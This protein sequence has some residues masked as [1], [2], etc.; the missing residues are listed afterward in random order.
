MKICL[1]FCHLVPSN[2]VARAAIGIAN[3]ISEKMPG[4]DVTLIPLYKYDKMS[5]SSLLNPSVTVKKAIGFYFHGLDKIIRLLPHSFWGKIFINSEY[6]I[7]I[8]F[9][10]GL[11]TKIVGALAPSLKSRGVK[12]FGW[13]HGY[14]DGLSYLKYYLSIGHM[15]CVSKTNA[16]RLFDESG[17]KL[18]VDYCYNPINDKAIC[19]LGKDSISLK[20]NQFLQLVTVARL[21]PEK[22]FFRLLECITR[23]KQEGYLFNLWIIGNG[24]LLKELQRKVIQDNIE[25]YV[26]FL[27]EQMNPHKFTSKADLFVCPSFSEG[28]STACTEAVMLGVPVLSTDVSG[29][30]EIT[31]MAE[32]GLVTENTDEGLFSGLKFVLDNPV[33]IDKWK[34]S[35]LITRER[36]SYDA[37]VKKLF[38]VLNLQK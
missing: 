10:F 18:K 6:D 23:L 11:P 26:S 14:D 24:P 20:P 15:I 4:V 38:T 19:L 5:V 28:Y 32:A 7:V 12:V 27:G 31:S 33:I 13:M 8:A 17:G 16:D 1:L 3:L 25:D 9:Q 21:S 2:G 35:V 29:A 22:G 36:F 37:R 34:N 30:K